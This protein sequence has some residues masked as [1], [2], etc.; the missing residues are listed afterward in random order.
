MT[1]RRFIKLLFDVTC[2][3]SQYARGHFLRK[4]SY[5]LYEYIILYKHRMHYTLI[6]SVIILIFFLEIFYDPLKLSCRP[7]C[8]RLKTHQEQIYL[9]L[10]RLCGIS[11]KRQQ[12][13]IDRAPGQNILLNFQTYLYLDKLVHPGRKVF[14]QSLNKLY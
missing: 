12:V 11:L 7:V 9:T 2:Y 4:R 6:L 1:A 3:F 13:I 5:Y 14:D 10:V 8:R